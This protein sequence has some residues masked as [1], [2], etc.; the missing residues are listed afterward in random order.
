MNAFVPRPQVHT[1]SEAIGNDPETHRSAITRL[2]RDQRRL[3][4]FVEENAA[5]MTG[6]TGGIAV[7]LIGVI[8]R[9]FD[10]AGGRLRNVTW[11]D[12]RACEQ[13]VGKLVDQ[14]LPVDDG[15]VAR[16]RA[17][18]RAQP[19]MLDEALYALFERDPQD[20]EPA[21]DD[22]E[23]FKIYLLMWVATEALDR[24]W[25]PPKA[26]DGVADYAFTPVEATPAPSQDAS[27]ST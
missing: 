25:T 2:I 13:Q 9:M 26:F 15:F 23:S 12:V 3:S 16:A 14:L 21:L 11:E 1:W 7:Y 22:A 27:A 10:L 24:N 4:K 8:L 17:V 19:H 20:G 18:Q 5:S 6:A